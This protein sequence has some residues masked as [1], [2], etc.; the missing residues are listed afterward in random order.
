MPQISDPSR[1]DPR[2][3]RGAALKQA[4]R[5]SGLSARELVERVNART[6]G[7]SITEHA[8][9]SYEGARVQLPREVAE[10]VAEVLRVPLAGLLAG[11]PDFP[12][13]AQTSTT[14]SDGAPSASSA[15]S[16][17]SETSKPEG[18]PADSPDAP[19][20]PG[21]WLAVR[22]SL[23]A[24]AN[25]AEAAA[26][27]LLRQLGVRRFQLPDPL[28][29]TASFELLEADLEG[30]V[31]SPEAA[32]LDCRDADRWHDNLKKTVASAKAL[33]DEALAAWTDL[34]AAA[35]AGG[36]AA[37]CEPAA[38]KLRAALDAFSL[39]AGR[40][41]KLAPHAD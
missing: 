26:G 30:L 38:K 28:I 8:I 34:A 16:P 25:E 22:S 3:A 29:F 39:E 12:P 37:A 17:R 35:N 24:R 21:R 10:R 7:N 5:Q 31:H 33:R 11:D 19:P 4:R 15:S 23:L 14:V 1:S 32:W 36:A 6:A 41:R 20:E 40:V 18:L 13:P 27:V 9:Y 2:Q